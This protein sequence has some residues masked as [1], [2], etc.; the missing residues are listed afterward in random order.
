MLIAMSEAQPSQ[1]ATPANVTWSDRLR[2]AGAG[3]LLVALIVILTY[4]YM[5]PHLRSCD[6]VVVRVGQTPTVQSCHPMSITDAPVILVLVL[7]LG[8]IAPDVKRVS[9]GGV[10]ELERNIREQERRTERLEGKLEIIAAAT[11][12]AATTI[13]MSPTWPANAAV[14]AVNEEQLAEK[15]RQ[16]WV[17]GQY[18]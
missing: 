4:S 9:I 6:D 11:A 12:S 5:T 10:I 17:P 2:W 14:P 13:Y 8:I 1:E 15:A 7:A 16:I 3:V 18:G